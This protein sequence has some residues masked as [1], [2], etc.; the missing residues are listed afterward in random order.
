ML[1]I[2][3]A[4]LLAI[5]AA[6]GTLS[7][8]AKDFGVQANV[9]KIEERDMRESV[10]E[11]ASRVDWGKVNQDLRSSGERFIDTLPTRS[12]PV[13][14]KTQVVWKDQTFT[15]DSAIRAP[16]KQADGSWKWGELYPKGHK[17]NPLMEQVPLTAMLFIDSSQEDQLELAKAFLRVEPYRIQIVEAGRGNVTQGAKS[18]G[19]PLFYANDQLIERFEI[20]RVPSLLFANQKIRRGSL[21]LLEFARPFNIQES[22]VWE[23]IVEPLNKA[24]KNAQ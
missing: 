17:Y 6:A 19:R 2:K 24:A 7:V 21:G 22:V 14:Q 8:S 23:G 9:W 20:K 18:I 4:I 3:K 11:S 10:M 1:D 15:L 5:V 12:L 16:L 13:A